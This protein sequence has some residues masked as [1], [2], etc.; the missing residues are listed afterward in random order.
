MNFKK[1]VYAVVLGSIGITGAMSTV[2]ASAA[3]LANGDQLTINAGTP[4]FF[5]T[6]A[7]KNV[8]SGSWFGMDTDGNS[9]IANSEKV[10]L[11]QGTDGII[12]GAITTA[13]SYH[14]GP[15]VPADSGA[16]V[17]SWDFF[18]ST[19]TNFNTVG[20]TGSTTALDFSGWHVAWNNVPS[21]DMGGGA[22]GTG[23][24]NGIANVVF[25]GNNYVL[26]YHATVP[27]DSP[28]FPGVKYALH[29]E[30]SLVAAPV[31]EASTYGMMLAG[32]GLVGFMASRRRKSI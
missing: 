32:L 20:I 16:V 26:D 11:A 8:T 21:I 31:P 22:W 10:A 17:D 23:F 5:T 3:A 27:S 15:S 9:A 14:F 12:I 25:T 2:N 1:T 18:G 4:T 13:G 6:G 30:G 28:N 7:V 29:L 19:G 24:T